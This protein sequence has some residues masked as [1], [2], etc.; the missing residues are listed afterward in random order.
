MDCNALANALPRRVYFPG[1]TAYEASHSSYFAALENELSLA[2]IVRPNSVAEVSTVIKFIASHA[3]GYLAIRGGGHTPWV[4]VA[5][6]NNGV[7]LDLQA[8]V[9]CP[10][11]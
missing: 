4:G 5:N 8:L 10:S 1:S 7:T 3:S 11:Q 9:G 6:I 2:C